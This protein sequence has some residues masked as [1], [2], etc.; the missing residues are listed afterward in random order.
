MKQL[1]E[2]LPDERQLGDGRPHQFLNEIIDGLT[3][4]HKQDDPPWLLQ[5]GHHFLQGVS[6]KHLGALRL[7]S[8]EVINFGDC[9][10][11]STDLEGQGA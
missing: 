10:I 4:L 11:K 5:L 7:I 8:Q 1:K 3:G 2:V 6:A 9:P